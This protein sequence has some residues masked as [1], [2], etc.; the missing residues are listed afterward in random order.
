MFLT[1]SHILSILEHYKYLVIFPIAIIEG[2]IIIIITGFLTFLGFLNGF[3]SY[4]ILVVAEVIGDT[5]HYLIGTYWRR[6]PW[7]KKY[8]HFFGYDE[9][10][11]SFI[12][13]HF[14]KH[15]LKTLIIGKLTYSLGTAV[16]I[17]AGIAHVNFYEFISVSILGTIPKTLFLFIVGY[18]VGNSYLKIN[19]YFHSISFVT[20]SIALIMVFYLLSNKLTKSFLNKE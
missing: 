4:L 7:V 13:E 14:K 5:L 17:A 12:E 15:K 9:K 18:Y 11:E 10:N 1:P 16:Q 19:G 3:L 6:A 20:I 2:P 8:G